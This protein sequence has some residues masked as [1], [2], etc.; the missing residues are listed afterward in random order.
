[1]CRG[2][3]NGLGDRGDCSAALPQTVTMPVSS[4]I[5][6]DFVDSAQSHIDGTPRFRLA[7][8]DDPQWSAAALAEEEGGVSGEFRLFLDAQL[9]RG[10][11]VIDAA[12]DFGFVAL[13]AATAPGGPATVLML[14]ADAARSANIAQSAAA[15]GAL[16]ELFHSDRLAG[17][18]LAERANEIRHADGRVFLHVD[19][20]QVP[21]LLQALAPILMAGELVAVCVAV[22]N[23]V[24][25]DTVQLAVATLVSLGFGLHEMREHDG[26][27]QLFAVSALTRPQALIA[28]AG[29]TPAADSLSGALTVHACAAADIHTRIA[30]APEEGTIADTEAKSVVFSGTPPAFSLMAPFCRTGY[31]VV[32]ANLLRELLQLGAPVSYFPLGAV[33]RTIAQVDDLDRALAR[34]GNYDDAGAS[35]RI[36]QQFDLA[37][38]VGRGP[39]IGFPIFEL[40]RFH[41]YERHQLARQER[42][43]VT[44]EWARTVLHENG[45]TQVPIDIVP[46]GVDRRVFH[47]Q[48]TPAHPAGNATVFMSVGKLEPRKGQLEL[49][50]AFESAFTPRD[51]VRLILICHNPFVDAATKARQ[52]EPFRTSPMTGRITLV[53][54][55]FNTQ[56]ELAAQM[57]MADCGVFPARAE[58]WNLE[59]LEMLSLGRT[60]IA[61]A[62]TAH[63]AFLNHHN[64]RLIGVDAL[65]ESIP[66]ARRGRWAAWN[67]RQHEQL[68][69]EMR[70]VHDLRQQAPLATNMAGVR[71][72]K[73]HSWTAS[74]VALLTSVQQ[75]MQ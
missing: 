13:S 58:G 65:E 16:I 7:A 74:A 19:V 37:M 36:S 54:T 32:G 1:M 20:A 22:G 72:A 66:G 41:P 2:H 38:H 35:V 45:V 63:T 68:V 52:L 14:N 11:L 4:S 62:C 18:T 30:D 57:A 67:A 53:T 25:D 42:L 75:G 56:S 49:L 8:L 59:A 15:S 51:A 12:P 5:E 34:Q 50:R 55:P 73:A 6:T 43:L 61:T 70:R 3:K 31:G 44:C 21:V 48:V 29:A 47:E 64:A 46:L 40:D 26:E 60:V 23:D 9:E 33:D 69:T 39:R 10:D 28:V 17:L 24:D 71:T 27:A